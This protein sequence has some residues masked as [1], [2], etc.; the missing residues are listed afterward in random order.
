MSQQSWPGQ[1]F[2]V[3]IEYFCVVTELAKVRRNYVVTEQF[4]VATELARIR[5]IYVSTED[6]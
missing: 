5:R 3:A 6:F 4:Y 1:E 2:S